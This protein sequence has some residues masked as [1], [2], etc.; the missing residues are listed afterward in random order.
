MHWSKASWVFLF[1]WN[2]YET[3][4]F[5][6]FCG[7]LHFLSPRGFCCEGSVSCSEWSLSEKCADSGP[8]P[9]LP[10]LKRTHRLYRQ[11]EPCEQDPILAH[12]PPAR[13]GCRGG[14]SQGSALCNHQLPESIPHPVPAA[15]VRPRT[16]VLSLPEQLVPLISPGSQTLARNCQEPQLQ[17]RQPFVPVSSKQGSSSLPGPKAARCL[18]PRQ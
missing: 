18:W 14:G 17:S 1:L 5:L 8:G 7:I 6:P 16:P 3:R 13:G 11:V 9:A 12:C 15:G 4:S 10:G 2:F